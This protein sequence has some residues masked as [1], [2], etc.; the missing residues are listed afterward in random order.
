MENAIDI[1]EKYLNEE[2]KNAYVFKDCKFV[3]ERD[4]TRGNDD[5][6]VFFYQTDRYI[7]TRN[8][9]ETLVENSSVKVS[10]AGVVFGFCKP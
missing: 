5:F 8:I 1:A 10:K 6:W 2:V 7:E 3:V 4:L 9:F